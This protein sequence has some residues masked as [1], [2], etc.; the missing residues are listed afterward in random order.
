MPYL[1]L[2]SFFLFIIIW[3]GRET[4]SIFSALEYVLTANKETRNIRFFF[5]RKS[6]LKIISPHDL[7]FSIVSGFETQQDWSQ[8]SSKC[9]FEQHYTFCHNTIYVGY[10]RHPVKNHPFLI[11]TIAHFKTG[12]FLKMFW[13]LRI[14]PVEYSVV[15]SSFLVEISSNWGSSMPLSTSRG[16]CGSQMKMRSSVVCETAIWQKK[17]YCIVFLHDVTFT[18]HWHKILLRLLKSLGI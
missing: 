14:L 11:L 6:Q 1:F 3:Q 2:C 7:H 18:W 10:F 17:C 13:K 16:I 8:F 5:S 4:L 9:K 15:Q 12:E